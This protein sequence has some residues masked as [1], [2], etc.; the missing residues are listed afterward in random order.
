M[1]TKMK[2]MKKKKRWEK[3]GPLQILLIGPLSEL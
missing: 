3:I 2:R 1:K